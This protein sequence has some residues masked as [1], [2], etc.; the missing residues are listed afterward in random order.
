ME[1]YFPHFCVLGGELMFKKKAKGFYARD[2]YKWYLS[3]YY[4]HY[5]AKDIGKMCVANGKP[6][7]MITQF[8]SQKRA[9]NFNLK[10][11]MSAVQT[12][13]NSLIAASIKP[14]SAEAS[15]LMDQINGSL[16]FGNKFAKYLDDELKQS[17]QDHV[18]TAFINTLRSELENENHQLSNSEQTLNSN[19]KKTAEEIDKILEIVNNVIKSF[20]DD[21]E[22]AKNFLI[23]L[24]VQKLTNPSLANYGEALSKSLES[25]EAAYR[26]KGLPI[27]IA[28]IK[29]LVGQLNILADRLKA[30]KTSSSNNDLT[31]NSIKHIFDQGI[32]P[33][34]L[35]ETFGIAVDKLVKSELASAITRV[36]FPGQNDS[37][38][39]GYSDSEG[40]YL[41][42][43]K[44]TDD[45]TSLSGKTDIQLNNVHIT[46]DKK[47][48]K[49]SGEIRLQVG[50]SNKFSRK[51]TFKYDPNSDLG[52]KG[53][54]D[55]DIGGG[56][57]L[58]RAITMT[59]PDERLIYLAYNI[60][61]WQKESPEAAQA[62]LSLQDMVFKRSIVDSFASRGGTGGG[63]NNVLDF[64][65]YILI[66]DKI[67]SMYDIIQYA[68]SNNIGKTS[69]LN[70]GKVENQG[71]VYTID[72]T[73]IYTGIIA[74]RANYK[75]NEIEKRVGDINRAI[76]TANMKATLR[77]HNLIRA[78]A[79][80]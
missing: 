44:P 63:E 41:T 64:S 13:Y 52:F 67:L 2:S 76:N 35:G 40:H 29:H 18:N 58:G 30:G 33:I 50:I 55:I 60:F 25:F 38:Y 54:A 68:L 78:L 70:L 46:V 39:I 71:I 21:P 14:I 45:D 4:I 69:A 34:G 59:F 43:F 11:I 74:N 28:Q 31:F 51:S 65:N 75:I 6:Q 20:F 73:D 37:Q 10:H 17:M 49:G 12:Q 80:T 16:G 3:G 27:K 1:I 32:L 62:I 5:H 15:A 26:K 22:Q 9:Y 48:L 56:V 57:K 42:K 8:A 79:N 66:N 23:G 19:L 61:A 77:P 47:F 24:K 53:S 36:T 7:D 72:K